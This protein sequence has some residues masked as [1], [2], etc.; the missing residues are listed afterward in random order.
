LND[1][2]DRSALEFAEAAD[3]LAAGFRAPE[4][5]SGAAHLWLLP[6]ARAEPRW[7]AL[8]GVYAGVAPEQ[9][10]L[11]RGAHG[12]P[13]L[14]GSDLGFSLSK[15]ASLVL[16]A[17]ARSRELGVDLEWLGRRVAR[18]E[19]LLRRCFDPQERARV[20]A[21]PDPARALLEAWC[22]KEAVVKGIG[23]GIAFGL[24][25]VRLEAE[26]GRYASAEADGAHWRLWSFAPAAHHVAA[27]AC[28]D[29][30][31]EPAGY[32]VA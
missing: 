26:G 22:A 21:S 27:L 25:R 29:A 8:L 32:R 20:A 30:N 31:L 24:M 5:R 2:L 23:R 9:L 17:L 19:A 10:A 13:E 28:R 1:P 15:S 11:A 18:P 14:A 4:L 16:F 3:P 6:R 7:R 12:K